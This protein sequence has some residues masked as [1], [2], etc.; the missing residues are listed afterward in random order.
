M[1]INNWNLK[2]KQKVSKIAKEQK[3]KLKTIGNCQATKLLKKKKIQITNNKIQNSKR[4]RKLIIE[5]YPFHF[6]NQAILS[7]QQENHPF[8]SINQAISNY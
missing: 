7:Y 3:F 2:E 8:D 5:N 4:T 1:I 6:I